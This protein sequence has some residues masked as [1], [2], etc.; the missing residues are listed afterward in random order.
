MS[1]KGRRSK[2]K[3]KNWKIKLY[4]KKFMDDTIQEKGIGFS[5]AI[6]LNN[7]DDILPPLDI[8]YVAIFGFAG[9]IFITVLMLMIACEVSFSKLNIKSEK[10]DLEVEKKVKKKKKLTPV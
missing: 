1:K 6:N 3:N 7:I 5:D 10:K 9:L 2:K 8:F 4:T